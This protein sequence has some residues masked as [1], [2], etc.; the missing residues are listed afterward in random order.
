MSS[1]VSLRT[2]RA[3]ISSRFIASTIFSVSKDAHGR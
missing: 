1:F 2:S 3:S